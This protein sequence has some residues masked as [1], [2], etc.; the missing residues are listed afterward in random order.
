MT[1]LLPGWWPAQRRREPSAG[2]CAERGK[3][4]TD[5]K[6]D[7]QAAEPRGAEYRCG[8]QWRTGSR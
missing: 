8:V 1:C 5:A 7:L 6:G 3:L 2:F 4:H